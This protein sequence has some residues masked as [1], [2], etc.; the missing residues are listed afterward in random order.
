MDV[1]KLITEIRD[2]K[3]PSEVANELLEA[4]LKGRKVLYQDLKDIN[5]QG[6]AKIK[7]PAT[8]KDL[9]D[10]VYG[11]KAMIYLHWNSSEDR[12]SGEANLRKRG[13]NPTRDYSP[14][15]SVGEVR[16]TYFRGWHWDE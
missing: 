3:D 13:Y 6:I 14:G 1:N 8:Y 16:V 7:L 15:G 10:E 2:G 9:P 5:N 11:N 12:K 4:G